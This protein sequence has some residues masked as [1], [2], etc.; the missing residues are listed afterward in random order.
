MIPPLRERP[1]DISLL[2]KDVIAELNRRDGRQV[3]ELAE[4]LLDCLRAHDWPGNVRELRNVIESVF[5]DPPTGILELEHLPP[6]FQMLFGKYRGTRQ[7]ERA[8]MIDALER[9][10]WNK[11]GAAKALKCSRMTLYR[12]LAKY[13]V[14]ESRLGVTSVTP[15]SSES[16]TPEVT[17]ARGKGATIPKL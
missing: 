11:A 4:P 9:N 12:K 3:G 5:I 2:A 16:D 10:R 1:D 7:S 6:A 14:M 13:Q 15:P 17:S 8:R